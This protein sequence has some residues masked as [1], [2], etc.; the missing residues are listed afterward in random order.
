MCNSSLKAL[1]PTPFWMILGMFLL[2]LHPLTTS[3]F[4]IMT[5]SMPSLALIL[6]WFTVQMESLLL[7]S[8]TVLLSSLSVW[9]N[10]FVCV[11]L[12]LSILL[13]GSMVT[14]QH[15]FKKGDRSNPSNFN[16]K[17]VMQLSAH[18]LLSDYQYGFWKGW[19]TDDLLAFLTE[20]WSSSFR[21]FGETFAV[22]LD[23]LKAFDR[24]WHKSLISKL[25]NK[26]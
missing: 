11:F 14:F 2:L 16:K 7:F 5:F 8:K 19:S 10:S 17:I 9:S 18:N 1:L 12:L 6:G 13:A 24:V 21:D 25:P 23:I 3:E 4:F 26:N 20:S 15:V 22:S